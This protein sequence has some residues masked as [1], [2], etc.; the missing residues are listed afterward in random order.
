MSHIKYKKMRNALV[1]YGELKSKHEF[2]QI[3]EY[4]AP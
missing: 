3:Y 2:D 4:M 1:I